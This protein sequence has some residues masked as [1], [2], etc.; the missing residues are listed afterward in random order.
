MKHSEMKTRKDRYEWAMDHYVRGATT[1]PVEIKES[2][3]AIVKRK[4]DD[5][6]QARGVEAV[7]PGQ[8]VEIW[9]HPDRN[10]NQSLEQVAHWYGR[11]YFEKT[12]KGLT[13]H[14]DHP[15]HPESVEEEE[16]DAS[17]KRKAA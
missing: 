14:Q 2:F 12:R 8:V 3:G 5:G 7:R 17:A 16:A 4:D 10:R 1:G 9:I 13:E 11:G 15:R 6:S